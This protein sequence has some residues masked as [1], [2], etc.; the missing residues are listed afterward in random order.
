[1]TG[2]TIIDSTTTDTDVL[3]AAVS[4]SLTPTSVMNI[5]TINLVA[6]YGNTG[7]FAATNVVGTKNLNVS[8]D[9]IAGTATFTDVGGAKV[10]AIKAGT[11]IAT[12]DATMATAGGVLAVDAGSA[13]TVNVTGNTGS[14]EINVTVNGGSTTMVAN[15][16]AGASDKLTIT[17]GGTSANTV[18]LSSN[19]A[20]GSTVA[21]GNQSLTIKGSTTL[22]D[23]KAVT[24]SLTAGTLNVQFTATNSTD[25]LTK[26]AAPMEIATVTADNDALKFADSST[27]TLS[28]DATTNQLDINSSTDAS[29]TLNFVLNGAASVGKGTT[30][31]AN[32][33]VSASKAVT[34]FVAALDTTDTTL[35]FS[36]TNDI[37]VKTGSSAKVLDASAMNAKLTVEAAGAATTF[38]KV[39][40]SQGDDTITLSGTIVASTISGGLGNDTIILGAA[41]DNVALTLDGGLGTNILKLTTD[42][43]ITD[44][45]GPLDADSVIS[46]F[47]TV[48]LNGSDLTVAQKQGLTLGNTFVVKG[49][50]ANDIFTVAMIDGK[51]STFVDLSGVTVNGTASLKIDAASS[52]ATTTHTLK[53][54]GTYATTIVGSAAKDVVTGGAGDDVIW[55]A[56]GLDEITGGGGADKFRLGAKADMVTAANVRHVKDFVVGT[57]KFVIA[58]NDSTGA[59]ITG[60]LS[61]AAAFIKDVTLNGTPGSNAFSTMGTS[62]AN[63]VSVASISDVYTQL[64][65]VLDSSGFTG[66]ATDGSAFVA[67]V[68][69][70]TTGNAAG[71]YLVINDATPGFVAA[72]DMVINITGVTG[73][74]TEA[75]F[76]FI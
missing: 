56:A 59:N 74:V 29:G 37:T 73:T 75:V 8:S 60:N 5:E 15:T 61:G 58:V 47:G 9:I 68:V 50:S 14:D 51:G 32:V 67:R 11:N 26:V 49:T 21:A 70:F 76:E 39:T 3:N 12:L 19:G 53:G 66:S 43:N 6:K 34:N 16:L 42:V 18:T 24:N 33:V 10:A 71:K 23:E 65:L 44:G 31:F 28:Q 64:A 55:T 4:G 35:K 20:L 46:N 25:D 27:V 7:T 40:G 52:T 38:T 1:M 36:G 63:T 2:Y 57:D 48:D 45:A 62:L 69:E 17:S 41:V 22:F 72:D 13:T 54:S 30:D